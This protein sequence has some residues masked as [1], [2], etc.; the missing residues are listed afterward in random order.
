MHSKNI[1]LLSLLVLTMG[2][3]NPAQLPNQLTSTPF[4]ITSTP[5]PLEIASPTPLP[6]TT[7][8]PPLDLPVVA[9]PVLLRIDFQNSDDG[10][11]IAANDGGKILRT[12][13]GGTTW[14]NVTPPDLTGIGYSTSMSLLDNHIAWV[15]VPNTDF[16][17]GQLY[18]TSDGGLTW[19]S[20][21]VPFGGARIQFLD[22]N[23][24]RALADR[25]AGLGSNSVEMFQT[26]DG[27]DTWSSVFFNDPTR[28]DSSES[29][30]LSGIKNG[31]TY[32]D[33]NTGWVTGSRPV[34]GEVYLFV[35]LDGGASWA[36]QSIP[37]PAGYESFQTMPQAPFFFKRDG[38]LPLMITLP[39]RTDLTFY[40]TEDGGASW[41]G[42]PR[43]ASR[44]INPCVYA[45]ADALHGWCWDSGNQLNFTTDGAQSWSN[46]PA[47]LDL[48]ERLLQMEF[49]A[50]PDGQFTGWALSS[51]D[52]SGHTQLYKTSDN[53]ETWITLI[54]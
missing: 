1:L 28:S 5:V 7:R 37:L 41:T 3:C 52:D 17:T 21:D 48:G 8:P 34:S 24:G 47:N 27:G 40:V 36:A 31:I 12:V 10:W 43:N 35:T 9:A 45:F 13:D 11:G 39:D 50:G 44:V 2:A 15:L 25:G 18:R 20:A 14:L 23:T 33:A 51:L 26:S 6:P 38:F 49:V 30:P 53:G 32:L 4:T 42:D 19:T 54:P 46:I 16:Y 22:A 29:L